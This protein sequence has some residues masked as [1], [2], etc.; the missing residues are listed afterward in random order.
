MPGLR[1]CSKRAGVPRARR[2]TRLAA[3]GF[4]AP[5]RGPAPSLRPHAAFADMAACLPRRP[6]SG[7]CR[8]PPAR[9][10]PGGACLRAAPAGSRDALPA[11]QGP[12]PRPTQPARAGHLLRGRAGDPCLFCGASGPAGTAAPAPATSHAASTCACRPARRPTR[13]RRRLGCTE[14]AGRGSSPS[15]RQTPSTSFPRCSSR[16]VAVPSLCPGPAAAGARRTQPQP[17]STVPLARYARRAGAYAAFSGPAAIAPCPCFRPSA[18]PQ[19]HLLAA[20]A[21]AMPHSFPVT[22]RIPAIRRQYQHTTPD[23]HHSV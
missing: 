17:R 23:T 8:T 15:T 13:S 9:R 6:A 10:E 12:P 19:P 18:E 14:H 16:P 3:G 22:P 4:Q 21:A 5:P 2:R 20:A 11:C 1:L 7:A